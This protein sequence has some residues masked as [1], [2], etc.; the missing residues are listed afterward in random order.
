[1]AVLFALLAAGAYGISDFIGGFASRQTKATNVLLYNYPAGAIVMALLLP[2]FPGHVSLATLWWSIG[3]GLA[4]VTGVSLMYYALSIAPMNVISP[5]TALAS[6]TVPVLFGVA[7]GER[8]STLAWLGIGL[9][10]I[11][12][13]AISRS[14]KEDTVHRFA[15]VAPL[16]ALAAGV[17]F[18]V[19]FICLARS[20][21]D[22]GL[23]PVV[24]ARIT[25]AVLIAPLA[26]ALRPVSALHGRLLLLAVIAGVLD[27]GANLG[28]LLASRHGYLSIAGVI[29]SLYPAGTVLLAAVI[30]KERTQAVQRIG[31]VIAVGAVVLITL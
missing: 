23:W 3:G 6:A 8:P 24:I 5:V 9:G 30:L 28:F 1:M 25:S 13:V 14:P 12:V 16:L 2:A 10:L 31:L 11:A 18:G 4:G 17:G 21:T 26:F 7:T 15:R 22:S 29:T 27:A 19:Y 20:G